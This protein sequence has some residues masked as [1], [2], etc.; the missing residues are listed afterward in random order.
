MVQFSVVVPTYNR[1]PT[2][3]QAIESVLAQKNADFELIVVDD[4]STD[5]TSAVVARFGDARIAYLHQP[6][7]GVSAARNAGAARAGGRLIVFLDSDDELLP[8]TLERFSRSPG[9]HR[10][11]VG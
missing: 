4:G 6:N 8:D 7:R 3:P 2:L 1:A 5:D 9:E 11:I 10:L